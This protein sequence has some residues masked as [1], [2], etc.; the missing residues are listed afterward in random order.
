[1][2]GCRWRSASPARTKNQL[3]PSISPSCNTNARRI[4]ASR[5]KI[6]S[7]VAGLIFGLYANPGFG[8]RESAY[9]GPQNEPIATKPPGQGG[10]A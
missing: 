10:F 9:S 4:S 8:Y 2:W 1:M 5:I 3:E 6:T 7:A